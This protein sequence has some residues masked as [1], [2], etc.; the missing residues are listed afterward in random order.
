MIN[1][2]LNM[3]SVATA[4]LATL[5]LLFYLQKLT[6]GLIPLFRRSLYKTVQIGDIVFLG[7]SILMIVNFVEFYRPY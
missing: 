4:F 7:T 5:A 2:F 3:L 1:D 6:I